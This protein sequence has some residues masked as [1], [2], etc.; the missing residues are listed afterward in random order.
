MVS[1]ENTEIAFKSKSNNELS[2][3][4]WLFR[5]IGNNQLVS[6]SKPFAGI[7]VRIGFPFRYMI[8]QT[9]F[10]HFCGGETIRS[11]E[12]TISHLA[13]FHVHTILDYSVEGKESEA[14]FDRTTQEII[15]TQERSVLDEHIPFSVFKLT[16]I[17][18]FALLEKA[19]SGEAMTEA[20]RSEFERVR[21]RVE[22][23]CKRASELERCVMMDA[24]E[25]W[26]QPIMD[27]LM[28]DMMR[29][30]N[31]EKAVVYNTFQM[32]RHDRLAKLKELHAQALKDDFYPG[33]KL[34][35]GA[36]MEKERAR[37]AEKGYSSP[38]QP[39]KSATDRDYDAALTFM[40]EHI[41]RFSICA[42][43]HNENSAQ[44]LMK[45]MEEKHISKNDYRVYFSQLLGMSDHIS[46]N[47]A[48]AG[49]N[50]AK[51][52]P[53]GPVKDVLPYLIRRAD[54]NT[55][56]AGQTGRE[57]KLLSTER[58]RRKAKR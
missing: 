29:R 23:I 20:E 26:I 3:A 36:Y 43:S 48:H 34:V 58:A 32:Y 7:A 38:I 46:F 15:D 31:K 28:L 24:E 44:L 39:D 13:S 25:S 53:Y 37:A 22:R 19:S 12:D 14:D 27:E 45:L 9:I 40:V 2:K 41:D 16:G 10:Q 52:V 1:F 8:R 51:Y 17:A 6:L 35:R 50:V 30:F 5:F 49:Y 57:L 21:H 54:E 11:C 47:L 33:V 42:G 55:S 18:R 56:V 4:W